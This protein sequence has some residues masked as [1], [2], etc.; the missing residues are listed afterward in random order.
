ME[1][2]Y[3]AIRPVQV[4]FSKNQANLHLKGHR[5]IDRL[6]VPGRAGD[7][8]KV[9]HQPDTL[10]INLSSSAAEAKIFDIELSGKG[11]CP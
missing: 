10:I 11:N 7:I 8:L 3:D 2:K 5:Q 1:D 4:F 9:R 6:L